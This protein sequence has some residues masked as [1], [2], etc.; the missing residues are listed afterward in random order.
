[1]ARLHE[2]AAEHAGVDPA[3][4][5]ARELVGDV[6]GDFYDGTVQRCSGALLTQ[7]AGDVRQ[8]AIRARRESKR[9]LSIEQLDEAEEPR[10]DGVDS[11]DTA[12]PDRDPVEEMQRRLTDART[13]LQ[14]DESALQ[15]LTLY[16]LGVTRKRNV[17]RTGIA[18]GRYRA[19]RRRV[20]AALRREAPGDD[21]P[22][23]G[24]NG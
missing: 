13:L 17:M 4:L 1:M 21:E 24:A 18:E 3:A 8:R 9:H 20:L 10:N 23:P 7:L 11:A 15:L 5:L 2:V 22:S 16:E 19:A 6:I 12:P 14:G